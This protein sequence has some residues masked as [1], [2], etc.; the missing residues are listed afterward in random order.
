MQGTQV[1]EDS[2]NYLIG[3]VY[4][5]ALD[6]CNSRLAYS[7]VLREFVL[8]Y[9]EPLSASSYFLE[10]WDY[11]QSREA[12]RGGSIIISQIRRTTKCYRGAAQ[13]VRDTPVQVV[14]GVAAGFVVRR[15]WWNLRLEYSSSRNPKPLAQLNQKNG[16]TVLLLVHFETTTFRIP[17]R[18]AI[19]ATKI[20]V[21][22][23]ITDHSMTL[24]TTNCPMP[25]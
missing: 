1:A 12:R 24:V 2:L 22:M 20:R 11:L 19:S 15:P 7:K 16:N 10:V 23:G 8:T 3:G 6:F 4:L 13:Q 17:V 25:S 14:P 5:P 18:V 9:S 21:P